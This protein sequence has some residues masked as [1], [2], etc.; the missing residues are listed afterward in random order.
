MSGGL[1]DLPRAVPDLVCGWTMLACGLTAWSRRPESR[2][3]PLL[4]ATGL[5]WFA[6]NFIAAG[7]HV[8]LRLPGRYDEAALREAARR[9][10]LELST[11]SDYRPG[12]FATDPVLLLGYAQIPE[13]A[14]AAGVRELAAAITGARRDTT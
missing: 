14:V 13:A 11:L 5:T 10:R 12:A 9:R 6:G 7:L 1:E 2:S 8:T 3:G 4:A